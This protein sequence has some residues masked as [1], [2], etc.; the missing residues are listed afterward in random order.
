MCMIKHKNK[1][2]KSLSLKKKIL[3]INNNSKYHLQ[4]NLRLNKEKIENRNKPL[5]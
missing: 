1:K 2:Y 3:K 5:L 4:K